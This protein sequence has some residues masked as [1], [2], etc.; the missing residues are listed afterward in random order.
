MRIDTTNIYLVPH[1]ESYDS[2]IEPV[3]NL[4]SAQHIQKAVA[5]LT[6]YFVP[7]DSPVLDKSCHPTVLHSMTVGLMGKSNDEAVV[8]FLHDLLEDTACDESELYE[9][10]PKRIVET[11]KLLTRK[12]GEQYFDYIDRIKESGNTLAVKVKLNDLNHNHIRS[13]AS[14]MY[15]LCHRYEKAIEILMEV[16]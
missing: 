3:W 9:S 11:V 13:H 5:L 8:G 2:Y 12:P 6:K 1:S 15:S 16:K 4:C 10:F 14:G 7:G